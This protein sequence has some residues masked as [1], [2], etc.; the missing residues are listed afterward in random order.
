MPSVRKKQP[1]EVRAR[2]LKATAEVASEQGLESVTIAE[3]SKRAGVTSGG[4]FHHFHT[5]K[6]LIDELISTC[7][8]SFE[9]KIAELAAEYPDPRGRFDRA[10][11]AASNAEECGLFENSQMGNILMAMNRN[12]DL[13]R[14]WLNWTDQQMEKHGPERD[15]ILGEIIRYASDGLWL[16]QYSMETIDPERRQT[17]IDRLIGLSR[18]L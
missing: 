10:Y 18:L 11:L 13:S 9:N 14:R 4:L 16:E 1:Q 12:P 2:L 8:S 3:V 5:K 7:M 6:E 17:V 15:P